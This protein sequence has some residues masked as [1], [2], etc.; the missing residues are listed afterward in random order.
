MSPDNRKRLVDIVGRAG[1]DIKGMLPPTVEIPN[2]NAY[3]HIWREI[4]Q[5]YGM[6]YKDIDDS[7]FNDVMFFIA[8]VRFEVMI[9]HSKTVT[10]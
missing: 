1:D 2:R 4:K 3:A 10:K 7:L 8:M 9:E 5:K 6:S